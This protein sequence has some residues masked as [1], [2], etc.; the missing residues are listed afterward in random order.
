MDPKGPLELRRL[1]SLRTFVV[2]PD[3]QKVRQPGPSRHTS[4][5][6]WRTTTGSFTTSKP[7]IGRSASADPGRFQAMCSSAPPPRVGQVAWEDSIRASVAAQVTTI[8]P[9]DTA[10][11]TSDRLEFRR[12]V[13]L[14]LRSVRQPNRE[15]DARR[16]SLS[17]WEVCSGPPCV[18]ADSHRN[19]RP[20][21]P[22]SP[23]AGQATLTR[24]PPRRR[25]AT[26]AVG[27]TITRAK[28][29]LL[30]QPVQRSPRERSAPADPFLL[31]AHSADADPQHG[32]AAEHV[33][34]A[35]TRVTGPEGFVAGIGNRPR[36]MLLASRAGPGRRP[37]V[38]ARP[39]KVSV[40]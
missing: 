7:V 17:R 1:P 38:S 28:S 13:R 18:S 16:N 24:P 22:V 25:P 9:L 12:S 14:L 21:V 15:G 27:P 36:R 35:S 39:W 29:P 37:R 8:I 40:Q 33:E 6:Q 4:N 3:A 32:V 23:S 5:R 30:V 19:R 11:L 31:V 10:I 26:L 34:R 2:R 20:R